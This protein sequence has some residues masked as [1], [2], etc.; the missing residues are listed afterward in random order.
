VRR[1]LYAS[2]GIHAALLILVAVSGSLTRPSPEP[3]FEVTGVTLLSTAEFE[4]MTAGT[5]TDPEAEI[6]DVSPQPEP[7][8][9]PVSDV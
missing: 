5:V 4:A 6:P 2:G 8:P 9:G 3:E 1:A 7:E